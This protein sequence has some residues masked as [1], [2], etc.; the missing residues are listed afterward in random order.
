M[1]FPLLTTLASMAHKPV[2][3]LLLLYSL[4]AD[5]D[6]DKFSLQLEIWRPWVM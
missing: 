3:T 4:S 2:S 6:V 1:Q 5:S